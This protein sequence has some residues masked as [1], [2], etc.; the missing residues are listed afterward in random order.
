LWRSPI[1]PILDSLPAGSRDQRWRPGVGLPDKIDC[2]GYGIQ[3]TTL[4]VFNDAS[5][6]SASGRYWDATDERPK[7]IAEALEDLWAAVSDLDVSAISSGDSADLEP[8]WTAIGH[9]YKDSGLA[10]LSSS[11]DARVAQVETNMAQLSTD[12]Y[13]GLGGWDFGTPLTYSLAENIDNLLKIHE[14]AGGWQEN[15][16]DVSHGAI[17]PGAHVH[18]YTQVGPPPTVSLSQ[19]RSGTYSSLYNDVLRIRWEITRTRGSSAWNT[20]VQSSWQSG[21]EYTSLGTHIGFAGSGTPG[22]S[23]PHGI[24]YVDTGASTIFTN[25]TRFTGMTDYTSGIETPT[26]T[27][28]YYVS[29]GDNLEIAIGKIDT[30]VYAALGSVVVRRDYVYDRS[31]LSETEREQTPITITHNLGRKPL[32]QVLDVSP[33]EESYWGEYVSPLTDI[34]IVH[35]DQNSL[36]I[37]TGAAKIEIIALF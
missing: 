24:N 28:T 29:Q 3:G 19:G 4:F 11:L 18:P 23:N 25:L 8:L 14:V 12:I 15:P 2:L 17:T 22:T 6:T 34:N 16:E 10:S 30:A 1:R 33:E 36:E 37:W 7:T 13:G 35:I 32:I 26:Y 5:S 31:H 21:S 27:S 9:N 20:D